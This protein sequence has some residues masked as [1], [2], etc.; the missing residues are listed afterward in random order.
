MHKV[1]RYMRLVLPD[2]A[3]I[4]V[5]IKPQDQAGSQ[6]QEK[7]GISDD[8]KGSLVHS[9]GCYKY[10]RIRFPQQARPNLSTGNLPTIPQTPYLCL[11]LTKF[12]WQTNSI[13]WLRASFTQV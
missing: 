8:G 13:N 6:Y 5:L 4:Q 2:I 10:S 12:S 1:Q 9:H 7:T 3:A 11:V